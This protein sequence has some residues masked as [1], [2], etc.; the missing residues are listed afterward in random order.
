MIWYCRYPLYTIVCA[1][2]GLND[3]FYIM[4]N[5]AAEMNLYLTTVLSSYSSLHECM[6]PLVENIESSPVWYTSGLVELIYDLIN[7]Q[8]YAGSV[9]NR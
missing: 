7:I 8:F 5:S 9:P 1:H 6:R 3:F 4:H 2:G